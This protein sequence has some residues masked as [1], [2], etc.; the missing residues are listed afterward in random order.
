M[1]G[2]RLGWYPGMGDSF[3]E[4][5]CEGCTTGVLVRYD[6]TAPCSTACGRLL[7]TGRQGGSLSEIAMGVPMPPLQGPGEVSPLDGVHGLD[8]I[9]PPP[10]MLLAVMEILILWCM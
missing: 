2:D 1:M 5:S 3:K 7:V 6:C 10:T 9:P 4:L 8:A